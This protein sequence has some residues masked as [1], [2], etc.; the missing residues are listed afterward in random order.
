MLCEPQYTFLLAQTSSCWVCLLKSCE[1]CLKTSVN[2]VI[3]KILA[4]PLLKSAWT[5]A[6]N[7][8]AKIVCSC[9]VPALVTVGQPAGRRE[10]GPVEGV[11][12]ALLL[13]LA[14]PTD[15]KPALLHL[16][17]L[18]HTEAPKSSLFEEPGSFSQTW[19]LS[20]EICQILSLFNLSRL[21]LKLLK[22]EFIAPWSS[23]VCTEGTEYLH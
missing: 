9:S 3:F 6:E 15:P 23:L 8:W 12:R 17:G 11:S 18:G 16:P 5:P 22:F 2:Q 13:V 14:Q 10:A 4:Q 21:L 1:P 19:L 20:S 7:H